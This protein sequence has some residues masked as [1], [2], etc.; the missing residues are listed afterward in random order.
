MSEAQLLR[1]IAVGVMLL[2]ESKSTPFE[3]NATAHAIRDA[4]DESR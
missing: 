4:L 2:L 1:Q 3:R